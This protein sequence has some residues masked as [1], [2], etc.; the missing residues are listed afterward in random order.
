MPEDKVSSI[1]EKYRK[2]SGD[3]DLDKKFIFNAK[4][5]GSKTSLS[6][7]EIGILDGSNIYVYKTKRVTNKDNNVDFEDEKEDDKKEK[8]Y[9][10]KEKEDDKKEK[11]DDEDEKLDDG[12]E[13]FDDEDEEDEFCD[14]DFRNDI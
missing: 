14:D 3:K 12:D 10:K 9:D 13:K 6:V 1:I 11:E 2:K 7:S 5:L 8:K 4:S